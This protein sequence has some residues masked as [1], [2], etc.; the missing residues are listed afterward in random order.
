MSKIKFNI[1]DLDYQTRAVESVS[2]LFN[3]TEKA[4]LNPIYRDKLNDFRK[5]YVGTGEFVRNAKISTG[6]DF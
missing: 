2:N 1:E 6:N 5:Q 3:N 4:V